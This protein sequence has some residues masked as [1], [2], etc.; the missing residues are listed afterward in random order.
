MWA[1]LESKN[2]PFVPSQRQSPN[3]QRR[4]VRSSKVTPFPTSPV[5]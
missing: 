3:S 1:E 4:P 5:T 2:V